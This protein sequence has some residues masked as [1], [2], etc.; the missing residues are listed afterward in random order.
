M[1]LK[2]KGGEGEGRGVGGVSEREREGGVRREVRGKR[3][4]TAS[5]IVR[6][7]Q[8]V[9]RIDAD[10]ED[11]REG[12]GQSERGS[13]ARDQVNALRSRATKVE[14]SLTRH[15]RTLPSTPSPHSPTSE[16]GANELGV[17]DAVGGDNDMM[18][19][20]GAGRGND[21]R[22]DEGVDGSAAIGSDK[23]SPRIRLSEL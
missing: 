8:P 15:P 9:S 5:V 23:I 20:V 16:K 4:R 7:V 22:E 6:R 2:G 19:M 13:D 14:E 18:W 11:S 3:G 1:S 12:E 10:D 21:M 17:E